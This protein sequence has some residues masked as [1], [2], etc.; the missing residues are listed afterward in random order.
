MP[1]AGGLQ[2]GLHRLLHDLLQWYT[3][4]GSDAA[5]VFVFGCVTRNS[6]IH[7]GDLDTDLPKPRADGLLL[8]CKYLTAFFAAAYA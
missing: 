7:A 3:L 1:F 6:A 8:S 2:V 4:L 5:A